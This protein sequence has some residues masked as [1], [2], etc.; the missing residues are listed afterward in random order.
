LKTCQ[1]RKSFLNGLFDGKLSNPVAFLKAKPK[2]RVDL[3]LEAIDLPY[4]ETELFKQMGL[5]PQ[6]W[7]K[8]GPGVHPLA[9]VEYHRGNVFNE[10]TGVNRD[11]K[12]KRASAQ[13]LLQDTPA[14]LPEVED[15]T[16]KE[17]VLQGMR[18]TRIDETARADAKKEKDITDA[19]TK[20]DKIEAKANADYRAIE[21]KLKLEMEDRLKKERD[22]TL[23]TIA[24]AQNERDYD[25]RSAE[26]EHEKQIAL[27]DTMDPTIDELTSDIA[28]AKE[29]QKN[30]IAF[31][32]IKKKAKMFESDA[33]DLLDYSRT[34][35]D[36]LKALDAYKASMCSGL[37]VP[38]LEI[39]GN[40]ILVDGVKWDQL[41]T[42]KQI[43]VAVK[44]ATLRGKDK[45]LNI[46]LVD[47]AEALDAESL[48]LLREHL[49]AEKAQAFA[50]MVSN[51]PLEVKV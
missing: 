21:A 25:K 41:N 14:D 36:A 15:I 10:R 30:V 7:P 47:G 18:E 6:A 31:E 28:T 11:E 19:E 8:V 4:D 1:N 48:K 37:P 23:E 17:T 20:F 39:Q 44:V 12:S 26:L 13:E 46:V 35:T 16:E 22:Q 24:D 9:A 5:S 38:G 50:A 3:M 2:E 29:R 43:E 40:E 49:E 45:K 34:L 27:I 32:A 33:A 51:G 42:S